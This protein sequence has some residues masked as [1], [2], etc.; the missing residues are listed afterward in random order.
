MMLTQL[1]GLMTLLLD[2][3][4]LDLLLRF[5]EVQAVMR[6]AGISRALQRSKP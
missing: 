3:P 2:G 6:V 1:R 4:F 5:A